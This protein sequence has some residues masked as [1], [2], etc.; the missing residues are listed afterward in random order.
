[1]V[2]DWDYWTYW[3]MPHELVDWLNASRSDFGI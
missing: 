2:D 1:L 3:I